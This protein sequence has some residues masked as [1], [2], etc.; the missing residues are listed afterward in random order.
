[1]DPKNAAE[2]KEFAADPKWYTL[3]GVIMLLFGG[4]VA[5]M[6]LLAPDVQKV[7]GV[8][9]WMPMIGF[10][11]LIL[12]GLRCL[13]GYMAKSMQGFILNMQGGI[14][15]CVIGAI[16]ILSSKQDPIKFS[17]MVT[18]YLLTQG[19]LR[20]V[21]LHAFKVE[22]PSSNRITGMVSILFGILVWLHWPTEA[23][24]FLAFALSIDIMFRGWALI[25][26]AS[27]IRANISAEDNPATEDNQD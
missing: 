25:K 13:D 10:C 6:S 4:F 14:L 18:A 5:L 17:Y 9:S 15:D 23:A 21:L 20:N 24:W 19:I 12:G 27:S 16:I 22:H 1:M 2:Y 26:L 3:R 7:G 11:L 8:F